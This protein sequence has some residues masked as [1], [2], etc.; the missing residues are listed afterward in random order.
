MSSP[1]VDSIRA[2]VHT[3]FSLAHT[4]EHIERGGGTVDAEGY[5]NVVSRLKEALAGP[6]PEVAR[7]AVMRTYPSAAELYENMTY[8]TAGLS[9]SPL[10]RNVSTEVL[11][12]QVLAR[13]A[14]RP[15]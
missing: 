5:R 2:S 12:T 10:E 14:T 9:R 13:F 3:V 15:H 4:L 11:A 6:L 8:E 1:S 7:E